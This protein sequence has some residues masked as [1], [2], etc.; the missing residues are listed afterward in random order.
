M[1]GLQP[2]SLTDT[3]IMPYHT[4]SA[5]RGMQGDVGEKVALRNFSEPIGDPAKLAEALITAASGKHPPRR[6]VLGSDA[7]EAALVARLAEV[8][9]QRDS[10]AVTNYT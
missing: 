4:I 6:L 2:G 7:S 9:A 3:L 1:A 10:A 5:P 8:K